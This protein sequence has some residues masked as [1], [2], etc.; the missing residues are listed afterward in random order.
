MD[1]NGIESF[2]DD[3]NV[4]AMDFEELIELIKIL[5]RRNKTGLR[6]NKSCLR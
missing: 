1:G 2:I 6:W 5:L 4:N 3:L